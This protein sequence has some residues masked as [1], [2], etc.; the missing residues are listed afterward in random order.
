MVR[1]ADLYGTPRELARDLALATGLGVVLGVLGPFGSFYGAPLEFRVFYWTANLWAGFLIMAATVRLSARAG[2]QLDLPL[3]F[4]LPAGVAAGSAP[5][6]LVVEAFSARVWPGAHGRMGPYL[7]Y[8]GQTLAI[9]EPCA[10]LFYWLSRGSMPAR[11]SPAGS[12]AGAPPAA[13]PAVPP[14][15]P[16]AGFISRLSGRVGRDLLC[17]QMEDHYVR[18]HTAQG[19]ELVLLPLKAAMAELDGCEGLQVHRSWWVARAAVAG[20]VRDGRNLRLR[21]ANG[22]EAPVSRGSVAVLREAG[23]LDDAGLPDAL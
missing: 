2:A 1:C 12:S 21:L 17:L 3:W 11:P 13:S 20:V 8:Y 16:G 18:A 15:P 10:L 5:L 22:L 14:A 23:W 6:A 19:S 9:A 4:V 7:E